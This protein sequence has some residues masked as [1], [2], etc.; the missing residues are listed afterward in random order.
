MKV[1]IKETGEILTVQHFGY[2]VNNE[3]GSMSQFNEQDCVVIEEPSEIKTGKVTSSD[4]GSDCVCKWEVK[5]CKTCYH[6]DDDECTNE[7]DCEY[8]DFSGWKPKYTENKLEKVEPN[9]KVNIQEFM[10]T[11]RFNNGQQSIYLDITNNK[12]SFKLRAKDGE[13]FKFEGGH[14]ALKTWRGAAELILE[15]IDYLEKGEV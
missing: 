14:N 9:K 11:I 12:H 7:F 5:S 13:V 15:A 2:T 6:E 3:D 10:R 4:C 8:K 1:R